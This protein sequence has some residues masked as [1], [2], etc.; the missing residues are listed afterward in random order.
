MD[1]FDDWSDDFL[2]GVQ[3]ISDEIELFCSM[4]EFL[5]I[6]VELNWKTDHNVLFEDDWIHNEGIL[7][8]KNGFDDG[9]VIESLLQLFILWFDQK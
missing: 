8:V 4:D 5:S 3:N 1:K 7:H 6:V 2:L 9:D